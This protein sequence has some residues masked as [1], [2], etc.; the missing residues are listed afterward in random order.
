MR[1]DIEDLHFSYGDTKVL[2]GIDLCLDGPGLVCII[3]PNGVGKSTLVK[4]INKL[5]KPTSGKVMI[6]GE[7]TSKMSLK[8]VSELVGYVPVSSEDCFS[9]PVVDAI[10]VGRSN[11]KKW[12][13]N[14]E[15]LK[16]VHQVMKLLKISDL[17]MRSFS[18][19]S[20]GQHQKV[21]L[22]RG[23]IQET[24][25]LILDEPTSNLDIK[26][27]VYV[28]ELLRTIAIKRNMLIIMISHDINISSKNAHKM[29]VMSEPGIISY[30]GDP[31]DVITENMIRNVYG[32]DCK[33]VDNESRP[34]IMLGSTLDE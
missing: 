31:N 14:D 7:D 30:I 29:I 21:A 12:R 22:A 23:L 24:E 8:D 15:D 32:V 4:C 5:L 25:I 26:H 2:H 10:L 3:G 1:I 33:L 20:A 16:S 18:E 11:R 13:T 28:T 9:M 27:Q 6:N 34:H 19:L 17:A